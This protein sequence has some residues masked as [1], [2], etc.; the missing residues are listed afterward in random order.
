M[1]K[2]WWFYV[3]GRAWPVASKSWLPA[4]E[5]KK[6][7]R[8]YRRPNSHGGSMTKQSHVAPMIVSITGT[9]LIWVNSGGDSGGALARP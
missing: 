9:A 6:S 3:A 7:R 4:A 2:G 1:A 8:D 5:Q